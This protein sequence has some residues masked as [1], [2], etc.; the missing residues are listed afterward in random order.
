MQDSPRY[1]KNKKK[2]IPPSS[3]SLWVTDM[4][5]I[6]ICWAQIFFV[7]KNPKCLLCTALATFAHIFFSMEDVT[8]FVLRFSRPFAIFISYAYPLHFLRMLKAFC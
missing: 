4:P 6:Q 7:E 2:L 5:F 3:K 8:K 1:S